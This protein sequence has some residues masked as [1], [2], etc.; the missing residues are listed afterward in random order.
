MPHF[1]SETGATLPVPRQ[2]LISNCALARLLECHRQRLSK[3]ISMA[4]GIRK[5]IDT[6]IPSMAELSRR[7]CRFC[8]EPCCVTNTVWLDFRDLLLL[9]LLEAPV[10]ARQAS[11]DPGV[12]CPHLGHRGCRL[13]WAIRPWMCIKYICPAQRAIL[14]KRG[15]PA[16]AAMSAAIHRIDERR[17]VLE[18]EVVRRIRRK[19]HQAMVLPRRE[20]SS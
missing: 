15:P 17:L 10:P 4:K 5:A 14:K 19:K 2:W 13:P 7:T 1:W 11:A 12:A 3:S 16:S 9:H 18:E 8:P 6:L 20:T